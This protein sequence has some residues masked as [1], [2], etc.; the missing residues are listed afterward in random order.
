MSFMGELT[1]FLRLQVT[2]K[3]DGIF[4][5]QDKYVD[6]ILKKFGFSTVKTASTPTETS[7]SLMKDENA[8]DV[9]VHLYRSMIGLLMYLPSSRPDIMFVV[10]ACARFQV[11]PKVSHLHAVKRIFRYLKGQPKLGLWYPKDLP[12][13]LEAY[14]DSDYAGAS[15]DR[16]SI[17]GGCQF[18]RRR[19]ISW[20]CKKQTVVANSTTKAEYVAASSCCGQVLWIQNQLLDNGYNFMNTK[21]FIDNESTICIVKN[22]VFHSKTKH[23]EIRHHFIRDSYEKRL[24]QV[25]KI[26]TDHNVADLL[27]KAFDIDDWNGL[28]MLRMKLGLKLCCQAKVNAA[29]LL[30]TAR[31]P[32]ELQPLRVFLVYKRNTSLIESSVR[33]DLQFN[34]EDGIACL[35]NT[36]IFE[37][38]QLMGYE[39]LSD[40]L[41]FYKSYFSHQ[42]KYLIHTILQCLSSKSTAWNEFGTN[43][44]S[45]VICLAKNQKFNFSKLIFDGMLR[46]LDPN[47]K[48]F[49]MYPRFL[50]LFLNNQIENLTP[51]FNDEYATPSHTKKVFANMRRQGKDFSGTVT[52]LFAT[53]L[54]QPQ[55]D[56]GEGSG[57]PTEPQHTPT[58][59]SPSNIEPIP[60]IASSSQTQK[61]HKCRKTK[62]PTEISQSS[63]HITLVADETVHEEKGDNIERAATTTAS[64]DAEQDSGIGPSRQDTIL[65]DRPAQTR[66]ERLSK[67]SNDP[68]L[69]EVL[70][71]EKAKTAQDLEITS[72]KN[73]VKK[74]EKKRKARTPQLKRRL[75][76][77]RIESSADK[78]LGDQEDVYEEVIKKDFETVKSKKEQ[79][80]SIALKARKESSDDDSSTSDSEDEE[81]AMAVRD[82]K[83]FFKR[84]G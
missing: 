38:L 10:C 57:Q 2:Q 78:S 59:A 4:I 36:K 40:R 70:A 73:R 47:S 54:I 33:R 39:N 12:F 64:L 62:R 56:V 68:P 76:K 23:I 82:F 43:I 7:K 37:N 17:T 49:L 51:T 14:T 81:Y 66:F 67:Q 11:T 29:R 65:G 20:Q 9:D 80:R 1:I 5:S 60:I 19:L 21:I 28:E 83:K 30:T 77:V 53:M 32:L 58:T 72:L 79:S 8:E 16:K 84:R 25:I 45:A 41:T 6:E 18:L 34:D 75:F 24:I 3:D 46:N 42:W 48:K 13:D 27:T 50:Q 55:A 35:I 63:G 31:L 22:P 74:L 44:A 69:S 61:T 71:L 26:H 15:L 52:P